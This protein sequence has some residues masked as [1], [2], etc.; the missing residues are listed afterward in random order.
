MYL[1][2]SQVR[3]GIVVFMYAVFVSIV[4]IANHMFGW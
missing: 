4:F 3:I 1:S 2:S